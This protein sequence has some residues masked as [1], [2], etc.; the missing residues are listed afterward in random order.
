MMPYV[1]LLVGSTVMW[2]G[3]GI[4]GLDGMEAAFIVVGL[5]LMILPAYKDL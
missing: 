5:Q 3:L 4:A 1:F 2:I